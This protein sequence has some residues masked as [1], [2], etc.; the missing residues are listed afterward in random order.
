MAIPH[1]ISLHL[2]VLDAVGV[3][4]IDAVAFMHA[5]G[6][7]LVEQGY[8]LEEDTQSLKRFQPKKTAPLENV[9]PASFLGAGRLPGVGSPARRIDIKVTRLHQLPLPSH[10]SQSQALSTPN[11]T[12][13]QHGAV[14]VPVYR[15]T[16]ASISA[17][18]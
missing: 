10:V 17:P 4:G 9:D 12:L 15:C 8:L 13:T 1:S 5:L 7:Q 6:T 18:R 14:G 2:T 3:A 16:S 11:P